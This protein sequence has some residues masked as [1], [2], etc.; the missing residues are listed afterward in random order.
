M[1]VK[2]S[3]LAAIPRGR[4]ASR[5]FQAEAVRSGFHRRKPMASGVKDK[6]RGREATRGPSGR[7]WTKLPARGAVQELVEGAERKGG[8]GTTH[9]EPSRRWAYAR[10]PMAVPVIEGQD[11]EGL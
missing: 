9:L 2:V 7:P 4:E 3:N 6:R 5:A 11:F 1:E 10:S 8:P